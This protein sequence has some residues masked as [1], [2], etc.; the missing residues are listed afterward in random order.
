MIADSDCLAQLVKL[1]QLK[2]QQGNLK[3]HGISTKAPPR[4]WSCPITQYKAYLFSPFICTNRAR[5]L[6]TFQIK[7]KL[8]QFELD[9]LCC[10]GTLLSSDLSIFP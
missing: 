7:V 9:K 8:Q 5:E 3:I 10:C 4:Q 2:Y 6:K 1:Q